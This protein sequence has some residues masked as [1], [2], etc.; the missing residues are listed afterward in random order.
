M[1]R[2]VVFFKNN[3]IIYSFYEINF[4]RKPF[5][6]EALLGLIIYTTYFRNQGFN[7]DS[8]GLYWLGV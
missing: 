7:S 5:F 1:L 6:S 3:S 8:W 4:T 2:Y